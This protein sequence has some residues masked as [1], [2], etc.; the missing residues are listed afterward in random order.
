MDIKGTPRLLFIDSASAVSPS[1][2]QPGRRSPKRLFFS[3]RTMRAFPTARNAQDV[4][5]PPPVGLVQ[6][7]IPDSGRIASSLPAIQLP[8]LRCARCEK[9]SHAVCR[10]RPRHQ[11][12]RLSHEKRACLGTRNARHDRSGIYARTD[13]S[14]GRDARFN[15]VGAAALAE[16][17]EMSASGAAV[18]D[19]AIGARSR[20]ASWKMAVPK[21]TL[22]C[23]AVPIIRCFSTNWMRWRPG[24][25]SGSTPLP[26][27]RAASPTCSPIRA[28]SSASAR[29]AA[30]ASSNSHPAVRLR[31]H[32][33]ALL[34]SHNL[35]IAP[36]LAAATA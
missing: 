8:P 20:L 24:L 9:L 21:A 19:K 16:L 2:A 35:S 18:E 26:R 34:Q 15:L 12:R 14:L 13:R 4:L 27:S 30:P 17:A 10:N 5:D 22:S 32:C 29:N 36:S 28:I 23:S 1:C 6:K 11:A 7:A 33:S 3:S 25:S 31:R